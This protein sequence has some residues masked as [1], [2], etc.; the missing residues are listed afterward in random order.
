VQEL[1]SVLLCP[2]CRGRRWTADAHR[3]LVTCDACG[4]AHSVVDGILHVNVVEE[5]H[6]VSQERASVPATEMTPELGGWKEAYTSSTDPESSLA[7]AYLA[8]PY[9]NDSPHFR[10]PGYFQNVQRFA[11]E[12]D[13]ILRHLPRSGMLLDLGADGTWSTA[14]LSKHGLTCIALDITDHLSL[15]HLFQTAGPRYALVN[16]DMHEPVFVDDAFDVVTAFNAMHHSKRLDALA[17]NVARML[18]PGG[19]LGFVEPYVQ[20]AQQEADFGAPQSALGINE[21]VHTID[22]WHEAFS[23]AG[24]ALE[25]YALSDSFNAIYRAATNA[26]AAALLTTFYDSAVR[27]S[28]TSAT[29]GAGESV[30]FAVTVESRG[31]AAWASR[32]PAPIRLSYHV[33]RVDP[34]GTQLVV[35]DNPRTLL[36]SFVCPGS[37]ETFVVPVTVNEPGD[38][39]IEFDLVHEARTWFKDRGGRTA[40]ARL[41]IR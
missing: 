15:A 4:R 18:K 23:Q 39:E 13:F 14:R 28:P 31:R 33:S 9:G 20:N 34:T 35:F 10:E 16:V 6:E 40:V 30:N 37:P 12:F 17:A 8:L 19:V 7:K 5:H 11:P 24:L 3:Q 32:G 41:S 26:S 21:N 22:R 29:A 2:A 36:P 1:L 25:V 38:Y 27:V